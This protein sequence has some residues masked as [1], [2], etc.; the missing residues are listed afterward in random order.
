MCR[1]LVNPKY[2]ELWSK[3]YAIELGHLAQGIPSISKG[4]DTVIFIGQDD[5]PIN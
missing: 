5:V 2:K 1:L 3:S 4:A